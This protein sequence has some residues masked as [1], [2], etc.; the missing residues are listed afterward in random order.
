[1]F[2]K[3]KISTKIVVMLLSMN[4]ILAGV[5]GIISLNSLDRLGND[6]IKTLSNEVNS[7]A[8]EETRFLIESSYGVLERY[9]EMSQSDS[10]TTEEAKAEAFEVLRNMRYNEGR[11]YFFL[12]DTRKPY[13]KMLMHPIKPNLEG[14]YMKSKDYNKAEGGENLF[15]AI[16]EKALEEG[17]GLLKYSWYDPDDKTKMLPK[18]TYI[19]YFEPWDVVVGTGIYIHKLDEMIAEEEE[20]VS[21]IITL[22]RSKILIISLILVLIFTG[23]SLLFTRWFKKRLLAVVDKMKDIASGEGDLTKRLEI[24]SEDEIGVLATQFNTFVE[25][26]QKMAL[27][28]NDN[29]E[30]L[31][32]LAE[33]LAPAANQ[34]ASNSEEMSNQSDTVASSSEE[35]TSNVNNMASSAEEMSSSVSMVASAIEEMN[36]SLNEVAQNCQKELDI[37]NEAN[38]RASDTRKQMEKLGVSSKEI[39]K[40]VDT[41]N[42]IADQTNLLALNAT[43]EAASAGEAGK[44]F[45]VVANEVKEL[46]RQT[47][48]STEEIGKKIDQIQ[49]DASESVEAIEKIASVIEQ[50]TDISQTIVSAVEEQSATIGEISSNI[51]GVDEASKDIAKNV[52][53]SASSLKEVN[54]NIQGVNSAS[55][56]TAKGVEKI[57]EGVQNLAERIVEL[58]DI[59]A[60]FGKAKS[61]E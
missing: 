20:K 55:S 42:D 1:M 25:K 22:E 13:P 26:L 41:I 39:G 56:D 12:T 5:L 9:Y 27:R 29:T 37:A 11:G 28:I 46:A 3:T 48:D 23:L 6:V 47:S 15:V 33:D 44:G 30:N 40:V 49:S 52:Q 21:G 38:T 10:L 36:S 17:E 7:M 14:K 32:S 50:V 54:Y 31:S 57:K 59:V 4:I 8:G 43:I 18:V 19:K 24:S 61:K 58:K 53:E 60:Q 2:S 16:A 45:A 51:S 35:A 34:I